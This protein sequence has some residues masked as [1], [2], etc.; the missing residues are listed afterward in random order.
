MLIIK[1]NCKVDKEETTDCLLS[2]CPSIK[3]TLSNI[4]DDTFFQFHI[5]FSTNKYSTILKKSLSLIINNLCGVYMYLI[6][7][8]IQFEFLWQ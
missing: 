2:T 5:Y 3:R 6:L 8:I 4:I 1:Y 7:K